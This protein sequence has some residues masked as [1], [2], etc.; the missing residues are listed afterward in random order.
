MWGR[1]SD[2]ETVK[3]VE[4]LFYQRPAPRG[5]QPLLIES[6][7]FI[8]ADEARA[9]FG[10]D[11]SGGAVAV[12]DTGVRGSHVDFAGR[13]LPGRNFTGGPSGATDD[14][15]GHG[16]HVAGIIAAGDLHTGIA[17]GTKIVPLKVLDD[18]GNGSFV[19][20]ESALQWVLDHPD[21]GVRVVNVSFGDGANY[22]DEAGIAA[23]DALRARVRELRSRGVAVVAAAGNDFFRHESIEG[24]AYPAILSETISAGAVYDANVGRQSYFD[25]SIAYETAAGQIAPFSQRLHR[26]TGGGARTDVF[27]PGAP[28]TASGSIGDTAVS[29]QSGTSQAAPVTSGVVLLLHEYYLRETRV[30]PSVAQI[31]EWLRGGVPI[32][33]DYAERD[34]VVNTGKEYERLDAVGALC[35]ARKAAVEAGANPRSQPLCEAP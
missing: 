33:D 13:M 30:A 34:N 15:N 7:A 12:V 23:A 10:V 19:A 31:E 17:P 27:A 16:T 35:L 3:T 14:G 20:V 4:Q 5:V 11:G 29:T 26:T 9:A 32:R 22:T 25:G 28:V 2:P 6:S 21:R 1:S 18:Y 24:M 8:R